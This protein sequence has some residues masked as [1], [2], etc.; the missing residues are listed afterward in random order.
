MSPFQTRTF[1]S[2]ISYIKYMVL[3]LILLLVSLVG[4]YTEGLKGSIKL[5]VIMFFLIVT[6]LL[7]DSKRF[8]QV[9]Y[10]LSIPYV[11]AL[12]LF[13]PY[14]RDFIGIYV[15]TRNIAVSASALVRPDGIYVY[16]IIELVILLNLLGLILN[17]EEIRYK[18]ILIFCIVYTFFTFTSV[19]TSINPLKATIQTAQLFLSFA[20]FSLL[21]QLLGEDEQFDQVLLVLTLAVALGVVA[22]VIN[23]DALINLV[24]GNFVQ[25]QAGRFT[26]PNPPALLAGMGCIY[27]LY[28]FFKSKFPKNFVFL[29]FI[30]LNLLAVLCTGSRNALVSVVIAFTFF[31]LFNMRSGK[32][33][34][35]IF[36]IIVF[37]V[38]V[39]LILLIGRLI[40]LVRLNPDIIKLDTSIASRLIIWRN[41]IEY[42]LQ[43]PLTPIGP[44]NF[45]YFRGSL[46]LPFAHNLL[47]NTFIES[48]IIPGFMLLFAMILAA[49]RL[50]KV[51]QMWVKK[52]NIS[53]E[54]ITG[55][56]FL[57]YIFLIFS[58]DQ[59]LYDGSLWRFT[60]LFLGYAV[61][62]IWGWKN[63]EAY[64]R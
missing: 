50:L 32:R 9:L 46:S 31:M 19:F 41:S 20:P 61:H 26:N 39:T 30:V 1:K 62:F 13:S 34:S 55:A 28:C 18:N 37:V 23:K 3:F 16:N 33:R 5:T 35:I 21:L 51:F 45:F 24:H 7:A 8:L 59:F 43:N 10:I 49:A 44:G 56:S 40:F 64:E 54:Q 6:F 17:R 36:G 63:K 47:L 25:R 15:E 52:V 57:I 4:L 22:T 53:L 42:I 2:K 29:I 48:G 27:S 60:L 58:V 12:V 11:S 14:Y 38:F